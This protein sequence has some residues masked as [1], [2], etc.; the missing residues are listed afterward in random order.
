MLEF[1]CLGFVL[2]ALC[3]LDTP[4]AGAHEAKTVGP[5]HFLVGF[6]DEPAY[7]GEKNF[8][9]LFLSRA[10]GKPVTNASRLHVQVEFGNQN[11]KLPLLP[12]FDPDTGLGTRG[13][14]DAYFI[15]TDVGQYTFRFTG[16]IGGQ[17]IDTSFTSG[18]KTFSPV[19]D[20]TTI[21][22]PTKVPTA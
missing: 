14:Y 9:V 19:I 11:V 17:K 7:A 8:V 21:E 10:G 20:P 1:A 18:P 15:P 6:G 5:Y 12:S 16:S 2:T 4:S 3:L 22:F 13:E